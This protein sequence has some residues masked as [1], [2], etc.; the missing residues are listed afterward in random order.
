MLQLGAK[1]S[2]FTIKLGSR[3]FIDELA[4]KY[5]LAPDVAKLFTQLLDRRAKMPA[6]EFEE[7]LSEL[8]IPNEALSPADLPSDV[9]EIIFQC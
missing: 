4:K 3:A 8:G 9:G 2:D 7:K 5:S 1:E 6:E